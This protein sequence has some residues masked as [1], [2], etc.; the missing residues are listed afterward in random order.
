MPLA[1]DISSALIRLKSAVTD[2]IAGGALTITQ[3]VMI[4]AA[5]SGTADDL[6]TLTLDTDLI[7]PSGYT[8]FIILKADA[9]DTITITDNVGNIQTNSGSSFS[10]TGD[11][12]AMLFRVSP[13]DDW[14]VMNG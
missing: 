10:L 5:E 9:G 6:D 11:K 1:G 12:L 13:S 14:V 2:T 4:V 8:E 7:M 3:S